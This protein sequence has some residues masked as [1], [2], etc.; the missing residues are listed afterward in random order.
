MTS[1]KT[2]YEWMGYP[3]SQTKSLCHSVINII[4]EFIY[5]RCV[6]AK[7]IG[8]FI[9]VV[10]HICI[11]CCLKCITLYCL[12]YI[13]IFICCILKVLVDNWN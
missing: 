9:T 3:H 6:N 5:S 8:L 13:Y 10:S 4:V 1:L 2:L 7:C 12:P 11:L